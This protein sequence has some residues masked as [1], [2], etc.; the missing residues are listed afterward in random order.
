MATHKVSPLSSPAQFPVA[1]NLDARRIA[2]ESF[3]PT[4]GRSLYLALIQQSVRRWQ[5]PWLHQRAI[6]LF[7]KS[8]EETKLRI[9][10]EGRIRAGE[11]VLQ[12][13][14]VGE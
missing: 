2:Q 11:M 1:N 12:I 8:P 10:A 4:P 9:Q 14:W 6:V 13:V 3:A 5:K 7:T